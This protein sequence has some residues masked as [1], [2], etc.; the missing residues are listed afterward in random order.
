MT[1]SENTIEGFLTGLSPD[2]RLSIFAGLMLV[3]FACLGISFL[4]DGEQKL[5]LAQRQAH[6]VAMLG[7]VWDV[8]MRV[9]DV[10][11]KGAPGRAQ[12]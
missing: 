6:G 2:R 9:A 10:D 4:S 12:T 5:T 3:P 1:K 8:L 11:G 7:G